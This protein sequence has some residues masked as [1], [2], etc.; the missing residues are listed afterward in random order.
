[1]LSFTSSRG[2]RAR[3]VVDGVDLQLEFRN[4][5]EIDP[6]KR[7]PYRTIYSIKDEQGVF[8]YTA[9]KK[10]GGKER[11]GG[12]R[13]GDSRADEVVRLVGVSSVAREEEIREKA[14]ARGGAVD[15]P[16]SCPFVIHPDRPGETSSAKLLHSKL[17]L[18]FF[19]RER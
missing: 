9:I 12:G 1:M 8:G 10:K 16:R 15:I 4:K 19:H 3:E 5:P 14:L 13:E 7:N 2:A 6:E 11:K 17:H 18:F